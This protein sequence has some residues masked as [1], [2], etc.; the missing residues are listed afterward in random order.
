MHVALDGSMIS[1]TWMGRT[2][3]FMPLLEEEQLAQGQEP[4]QE[5]DLGLEL[6]RQLAVARE[7]GRGQ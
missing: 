2:T 6:A 4:E 7:L 1:R 3:A 5:L